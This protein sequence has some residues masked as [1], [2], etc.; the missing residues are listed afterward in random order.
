MANATAAGWG[1]LGGGVAQI[2]IVWCLFKPFQAM[3]LSDDLSWRLSMVVPG[4]M[5]FVVALMLKRYCWDTPEHVRFRSAD[6]GKTTKAS[7]WDYVEVLKDFRVVVMIFQYSACFGTELAMNAQL[8]THF[9]TYFEMDSGAAAVLAGSFGLMNLFD[10]PF[11]KHGFPGRLWAQ[12]MAL[13][14]EAIFLF[15]FAFV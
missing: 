12:F 7:L 9:R 11:L 5:F 10:R 6:V 13:L 4:V 14:F 8:A 3:G 15:G 1:N 2:F